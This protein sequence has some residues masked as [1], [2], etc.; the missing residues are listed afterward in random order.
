MSC[1]V[2]L[3]L[4]CDACACLFVYNMHSRGVGAGAALPPCERGR[5]AVSHNQ[6]GRSVVSIQRAAY[7]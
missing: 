2:R 6:Q 5:V 1:R 7:A 4:F 3:L